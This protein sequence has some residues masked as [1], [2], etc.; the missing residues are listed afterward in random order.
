MF[1]LQA[2]KLFGLDTTTVEVA[3]GQIKGYLTP[4]PEERAASFELFIELSSRTATVTLADEHRLL[5]SVLDNMAIMPDITR[6]VLRRHGTA[7]AKNRKDGNLAL[8]AVALRVVNEIILPRLNRWDPRLND[9]LQR[10]DDDDGTAQDR[11][12]RWDEYE[13][14]RADLESM[15]GEI[16]AYLDTLAKIAGT[17]ELADLVVPNPPSAPIPPVT[18]QPPLTPRPGDKPR[19]KMVEWV[20]PIEGIKSALAH[21]RHDPSKPGGRDPVQAFPPSSMWPDSIWGNLDDPDRSSE[22]WVDYVADM[23]DGFDSTAAVAWQLTRPWVSLPIDRTGELPE[24]PAQLPRGRLLVMGGDQLYPYASEEGYRQQLTLP[25]RMVAEAQTGGEPPNPRANEVVAIPGNHDWIGG[26]QFFHDVFVNATTFAEHWGAPQEERWWAV[27]LPGNWW[28]WG[29]DTALDNTFGPDAQLEY[30]K[31]AAQRLD[32]GEQVIVCTPVPMWQLRQKREEEYRDL[33]AVLSGLILQRGARAPLWISGDS[34]FFAHYRR[35]DGAVDEHHITA[36]GGGAFLQPTHNL[37]EHVPYERGSTD[38]KLGSRWP[39]PVDSRSLGAGVSAITQRQF[40]LLFAIVGLIQAAFAALLS[41]RFQI[42]DTK[43]TDSSIKE[44]LRLVAGS[45]LTWPIL[46]LLLGGMVGATIPNSAETSLSKGAKKYG[47]IHGFAQIAVF[48]GV[49]AG[50]LWVSSEWWWRYLVAPAIGGILSIAVFVRFIKWINTSIRANDT[51][52]FSSVHLTRYKQFLRMCFHDDGTLDV[53]AIG[54]DPVGKGWFDALTTEDELIPPYDKAGI[55]HLHYVWGHRFT[56][57]GEQQVLEL[58]RLL[59]RDHPDTIF[60]RTALAQ[61]KLDAGE[62]DDA[63]ELMEQNLRSA[64][65]TLGSRHLVTRRS[66]RMLAETLLGAGRADRAAAVLAPVANDPNAMNDLPPSERY[67]FLLSLASAAGETGNDALAERWLVAA[68]NIDTAEFEG[69]RSTTAR[70]Q[71]M[72]LYLSSGRSEEAAR[73]TASVAADLRSIA[74]G[75][76]DGV[77][78]AGVWQEL[79]QLLARADPEAA[80]EPLRTAATM[81]EAAELPQSAAICLMQLADVLDACGRRDEA[82]ATRAEVADGPLA[83]SFEGRLA[84]ASWSFWLTSER[85]EA[86]GGISRCEEALAAAE[87]RFGPS[88]MSSLHARAELIHVL[89]TLDHDRWARE[90]LALLA[91]VGANP[92]VDSATRLW[93]DE[94]LADAYSRLGDHDAAVV[95]LERLTQPSAGL[96]RSS[97]AMHASKVRLAWELFASGDLAA[98]ASAVHS[99]YAALAHRLGQSHPDTLSARLEAARLLR[100]AGRQDDAV[101][102]LGP[103][104]DAFDGHEML[105]HQAREELALC[106]LAA[107]AHRQAAEMLGAWLHGVR[108]DAAVTAADGRR[109]LLLLAARAEEGRGD[110]DAARRYLDRAVTS[111]TEAH[112]P[113]DPVAR[114]GRRDLA[115]LTMEHGTPEEAVAAAGEVVAVHSGGISPVE[116]HVDLMAL[117][118]AYRRA[119]RVHDA[120]QLAERELQRLAPTAGSLAEA[121]RELVTLVADC[122]LAVGDSA[123]ALAL[124]TALGEPDRA[125]RTFAAA[126]V[127]LLRAA[128]EAAEGLPEQAQRSAALARAIVAE[129]A[130]RDDPNRVEFEGRLREVNETI[131][132]GMLT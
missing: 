106:W 126:N 115:R 120:L 59:G 90:Q 121:S 15:R 17:P 53:Y 123:R 63:I 4:T 110:V 69:G 62:T 103:D 83:A 74:E 91:A 34:H 88:N 12:R 2:L 109:E 42:F 111:A 71:L 21:H 105:A 89:I 6:E 10:C 98:A 48:I 56:R 33:R 13:K 11:E 117:A 129:V 80:V 114:H 102:F 8:A 101:R 7:S 87:A 22:T 132:A 39:R 94:T 92:G 112:G 118:R 96:A 38:F 76:G 79:G 49:A 51:L 29:I 3:V 52:A 30:F 85:E 116:L 37:P 124:V 61:A 107:G 18:L 100:S 64:Q 16:R 55:S 35:V 84:L 77:L 66:M 72:H 78:A 131:R 86:D 44:S 108:D 113:L 19:H 28:M 36:G 68:T 5:R 50:G 43:A 73:L 20:N 130:P 54:I 75:Y 81:Y 97:Q 58:E 60:H 26:P 119:G 46:L 128:A 9:W 125:D 23:G 104:L 57:G 65:T 25:Y 70:E 47:A 95:I 27:R 45:W 1:G 40:F 24:P 99:A 14:C 122:S 31:Q 93:V 127:V 67:G 41:S 82:G 32:E